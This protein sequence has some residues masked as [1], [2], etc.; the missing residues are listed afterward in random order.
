MCFLRLK[1]EHITVLEKLTPCGS[2]VFLF[3]TPNNHT[4]TEEEMG[5]ASLADASNYCRFVIEK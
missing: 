2:Y 5:D 1:S 4:Y 3:Q